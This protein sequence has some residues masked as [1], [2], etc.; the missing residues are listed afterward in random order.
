MPI[1]RD[2]ARTRPPREATRDRLLR[3]ALDAFA[4][5]DFAHTSVRDITA[6]ASANVAA[7][8]YHF[9]DKRGLYIAAIAFAASELLNPLRMPRDA[10]RRER[11]RPR[12]FVSALE[13]VMFDGSATSV[14]VRVI[15]QTL[16]RD[17][18]ALHSALRL[19]HSHAVPAATHAGHPSA[20]AEAEQTMALGAIVAA[21]ASCASA[22]APGPVRR[23]T[24]DALA[25]WLAPACPR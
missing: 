25:D 16:A 12:D 2:A 13:R 24:V 1:A 6:R 11:E 20:F 9:G 15:S 17:P 21:A 22:P 3:V 14:A 18:Q 7:V 10:T 19:L 8:H 23:A 4:D 5:R